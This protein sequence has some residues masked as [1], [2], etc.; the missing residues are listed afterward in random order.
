M[1]MAQSLEGC[2]VVLICLLV[3]QLVRIWQ[4]R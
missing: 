2:L 1:H 3:W 4:D